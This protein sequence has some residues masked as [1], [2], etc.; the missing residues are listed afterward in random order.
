MEPEIECL[1]A[2]GKKDG[3]GPLTDGY[4]FQ[5]SSGL[6]REYALPSYLKIS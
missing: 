3:F 5:C 6:A 1:S 4:M 2:H